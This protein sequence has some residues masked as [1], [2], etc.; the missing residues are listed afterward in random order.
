MTT[1]GGHR[2]GQQQQVDQLLGFAEADRGTEMISCSL[3]NAMI[4][5]QNEID[6]IIAANN[7][8]TTMCTVGDSWCWNAEK[9][10]VSMNS[11]SAMSATV[12]TA[13][14]V[15]ERDQ[16]GHGGHLGQPRRWNAQHDADHQPG[17]DQR[18]LVGVADLD[19]SRRH[20]QRHAHRSD[21]VAPAPPSWAR[22]GPSGRR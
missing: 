19:Q 17:D 20:G 4:E 21:Q 8:A 9:P 7:E 1:R 16:L 14:A 5:P 22:S 11:A 12:P 2:R 6:P 18:P 13:D 3:P 15:E 10:S